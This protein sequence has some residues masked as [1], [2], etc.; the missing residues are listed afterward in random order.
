MTEV[1]SEARA[2]PHAPEFKSLRWER[3]KFSD[4]FNTEYQ[5]CDCRICKTSIYTGKFRMIEMSTPHLNRDHFPSA[6]EQIMSKDKASV[7]RT[8][9]SL[10][11]KNGNGL[12]LKEFARRLVRDDNELA[13]SWFDNKAGACDASR[14]EGNKTRVA[15]ERTATK[16]AKRK[17]KKSGGAAAPTK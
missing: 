9:K 7:S 4:R 13:H 14:S 16:S 6:K 8:I 17:S 11:A 10:H 3:E 1:S 5:Y 2:C 15:A 12:S